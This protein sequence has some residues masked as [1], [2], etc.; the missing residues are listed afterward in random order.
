MRFFW[1]PCLKVILHSY[2]PGL[3]AQ[4][5]SMEGNQET[6]GDFW[7]FLCRV[8]KDTFFL[9][10]LNLLFSLNLDYQKA[11]KPHHILHLLT[12]LLEGSRSL[13]C[14]VC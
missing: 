5:F 3:F 10:S 4:S 2:R 14:L 6:Y 9:L 11:C 12:Y 8:G 7:K 1:L 13:C